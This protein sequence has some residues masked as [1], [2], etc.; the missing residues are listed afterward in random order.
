V[1]NIK[2]T[3]IHGHRG[4]RGYFPENTIPGFLHALQFKLDAIELDVVISKDAQVVV[5]HE[6][7]MHSKKC[8]WPNLSPISKTQQE[9]LLLYEMPYSEI[10]MF[11]CGLTWHPDYPLSKSIKAHKPLLKEV[12]DNVEKTLT[13][14]NKSIIYNI[15][16]KSEAHLIGKAQPDYTTFVNLVLN[17][18]ETNQLQ[19]RTIIQSFD[20][21]ILRKIN[22]TNNELC[23]S[24]LIED[25][26]EPLIHI[27]NLGFVPNILASDYLYL[28]ETK[29]KKLQEFGI[30]VYAFTVNKINDIQ[31]MLEYGVDAIITDYPDIAIKCRDT[32]INPEK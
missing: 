11:D 18:I 24:L 12:I 29:V 31:K 32:Y 20:K 5:S 15:E 28:T 22:Q 2:K 23:L 9:S 3:E 16:I 30:K 1:L 21:E 19:E 7:F 4:C 25:E 26:I 17:V 6:H 8:L 10:K 13:V 27:E 14:E